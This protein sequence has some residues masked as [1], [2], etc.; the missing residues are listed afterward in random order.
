[1][2]FVTSN[3]SSHFSIVKLQIQYEKDVV[4]ARQRARDLAALLKFHEQ[5]Q[6]RIATAVSE[7]ARNVYQYVG[8]GYVEFAL[9]LAEA[10]QSLIITVRDKGQGISNLPEIL[11]GQYVSSTGMGIG[12]MGSKKLMDQFSIESS[13]ENGTTIVLS[14]FLPKSHQIRSPKEIDLLTQT[15]QKQKSPDFFDEIRLQNQELIQAL[16]Q[17]TEKQ[18]E[19]SQLNQELSETNR[20][21]V[22]LYAELDEKAVSLQKAN[23][24]KTSF[25][26]NMTHEFRT[27]LTSIMSLS[28]LLL[29]RMDG[30]LSEE[31]ERQVRYIRQSAE[32]LLEL[33][34]D[35]LDLAKVEAGKI[36]MKADDFELAYLF[37]SLRGVFRP[38]L[39]ADAK[40]TLEFE[41]GESFQVHS[42]ESKIGQ[43]LRNLISN[44]LKYTEK[45]TVTVSAELDEASDEVSISVRDTGI[46]IAAEHQ[47]LIFKDF[48]QIDSN[49]QR[50]SR[51][52]GLG[53]PLSKK[54]ARLLGGDLTVRSDLNQGSTFTV[55]FPRVYQG[56][57]E[58]FLFESPKDEQELNLLIIDPDEASRYVLKTTLGSIRAFRFIEV[59][60]AQEA[61]KQLQ[62]L[63]PS[64]IFMELAL[65]DSNGFELIRNFKTESSTE[66]IPVFINTARLLSSDEQDILKQLTSGVVSKSQLQTES[67]KQ[68]LS[69]ALAKLN[70]KSE[71]V[72][73]LHDSLGEGAML[74]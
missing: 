10:E 59:P 62:N 26:S 65:P 23:E 28:R 22:A 64:A 43:I 31:Q 56:Q 36:S 37:G 73:S 54:L 39:P 7:L 46:G 68:F 38:L 44:A 42:D 61:W 60:S 18:E 49:L 21:V 3:F 30:E 14:K 15:V 13:P 4:L 48:T 27:P 71:K 40:V 16:E 63:K 25:L 35:L 1:V 55:R 74:Q 9:N 52:T 24:I 32:S 47:D 17:L 11:R 19:L 69:K 51:G 67:S 34:S 53:L 58:G 5:D 2:G 33:V 6:I 70:S 8:L 12:L 50:Q 66:E 72:K 20:G 57:E 41:I 45:G 29:D